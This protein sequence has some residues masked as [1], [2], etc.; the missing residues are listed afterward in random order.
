MN[1]NYVSIDFLNEIPLFDYKFSLIN[2]EFEQW[3]QEYEAFNFEFSGVKFKSRLAKKTP[4]KVG[5]FVA[6]W[7]KN[8]INKNRPF[9]FKESKDK[10]II[11]ILDGSKK[12]QFIFPKELLFKKGII[13]S[14]KHKGKMA[15]RVYPSWERDL[16]KTAVSTQKWQI[17]YFL[18]F[19]KGFDE[20][21][22]KELY[23][24]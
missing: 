20:E 23:L 15:I 7:C 14:E 19:T 21:K 3:N 9:N 17:P 1:S 8:E 24:S 18:D 5:Y 12:G 16:N 22:I 13:S 2:H 11:N 6:F 4:K 10:L